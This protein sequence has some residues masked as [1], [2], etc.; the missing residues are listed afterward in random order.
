VE[1]NVLFF[2]TETSGLANFKASYRDDQPWI[3][4]LGFILSTK[5]KIY[6][7]NSFLIKPCGRTISKGAKDTHGITED[8]ADNYGISEETA[9]YIFLE[10][11]INAEL[12]AGHNIAFDKLLVAHMLYCNNFGEEAELLMEHDSFCTMLE[13][14]NICKIGQGGKWKWPK[15]IELYRHLFGYEFIGAHDALADVEA[16]RDCYYR[17]IG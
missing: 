15:L 5:N 6:M 8:E 14:T 9:C 16:T 7:R 13:G 10:A 11:L 2:D 4:Q 17:M 3:V 1:E 12:T